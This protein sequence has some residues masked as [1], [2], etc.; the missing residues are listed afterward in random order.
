VER[1][2]A[3][4]RRFLEP[5]GRRWA[6]VQAVARRATQIAPAFGGLA[7]LLVASAYLHDIGYAPELARTGFHPL[8]GGRFLQA[9][10]CRELSSLVAHHSGAR[11]EATLRGIP[12]YEEEFPYEDAPLNHALTFCDMT[13]GPGGDR[14]GLAARVA[15]ISA[16]YGAGHVTARAITACVPEFERNIA[17]TL[18]L[19]RAAG[20][21]ID[22]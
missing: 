15:E 4:A 14:V 16:R 2:E 6:H 12:D 21:Q 10:G 17:E 7:D 1:A 22:D 3:L 5:L 8:D 20:I 19:V 13:T 18:A 11:T 9:E